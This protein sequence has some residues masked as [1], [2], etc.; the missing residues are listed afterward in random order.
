VKCCLEHIN[1]SALTGANRPTDCRSE[2]TARFAGMFGNPVCKLRARFRIQW[3]RE[4]AC[5]TISTN[6]FR[7]S[8]GLLASLRNAIRAPRKPSGVFTRT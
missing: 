1:R 5:C 2:K 8:A 6:T 7:V 3:V 4:R